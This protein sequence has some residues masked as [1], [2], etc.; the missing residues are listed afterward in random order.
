MTPQVNSA[1]GSTGL[2]FYY[3]SYGIQSV[4]DGTS[5]TVAF[6]EQLVG[7]PALATN[8]SNTYRG[9]SVMAVDG[10]AP[11]AILRC[12]RQPGRGPDSPPSVQQLFPEGRATPMR[13]AASTGR[14]VPT[15]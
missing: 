6:S 1:T 11:D 9:T 10:G 3:V 13:G 15:G 12:Q 4:T 8:Y 2:F 14:S 7:N 5:N